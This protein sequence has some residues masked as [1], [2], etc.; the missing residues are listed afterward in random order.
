MIQLY[1]YLA[2]TVG[3]IH[4]LT[5]N[6]VTMENVER[7]CQEIIKSDFV[8]VAGNGGSSA[9]ASHFAEDI[10][11]TTR[12]PGKQTTNNIKALALA[13]HNTLI[14]ALANDLDYSRIFSEQLRIY[15][16][17]SQHNASSVVI[18]ISGS[19]NSKNILQA[20]ETANELNINVYA[21]LGLTGGKA[22][23]MLPSD[24]VIHVPT[25]EIG[26]AESIHAIIL[27]YTVQKIKQIIHQTSQHS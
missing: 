20:I 7:L 22:K 19:G 5:N 3:Y 12:V 6:N 21:L 23:N 25:N 24:H 15:A 18:V 4:D 9:N 13:D 1:D 11:T 8:Y 17:S 16:N 27:D 10:M 26:Q 14:T 2:K